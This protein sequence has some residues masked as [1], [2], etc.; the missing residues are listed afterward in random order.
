[1]PYRKALA[2]ILLCVLAAAFSGCSF[3]NKLQSRGELNRG[4]AA[5]KEQ[6][7]EEAV[8]CF[9]NAMQMDPSFV[10]PISYMA[11]CYAAMYVPGSSD[12]SNV[13]N[14]RS[15]ISTFETVL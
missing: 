7:Y 6:K 3:Y 10:E 14:A 8:K 15:A 1:M 4:V 9:K 12:S 5:F 2:V 11:T 13:K